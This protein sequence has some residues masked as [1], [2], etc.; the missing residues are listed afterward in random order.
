MNGLPPL[1]RDQRKVDADHLKLLAIFHFIGCGLGLLGILF[2]LGH[3][4]FMSA[5]FSNP[6]MWANQR[7][8]PP[9]Q[10]IFAIFKVAYLVFGCWFLISVIL[11][12]VSGLF[13]LGRKHRIFSLVVAA[14]NCLH[15]PLGTVL[16][17]F[18]IVVLIR[19]SVLELYEYTPSSRG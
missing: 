19:Q 4:A 7:Q 6:K 13:I 10:E 9:P 12:L 2:V 18:T 14:I 17:V 3:Y 8:G 15:I 1:V 5:I 11:N 16:G